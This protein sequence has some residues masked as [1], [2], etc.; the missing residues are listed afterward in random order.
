MAHCHR[1]G[2]AEFRPASERRKCRPDPDPADV[3]GRI[4]D[5][6]AVMTPP[7]LV[8]RR[9]VR[10]RTL[11]HDPELDV[12]V[13][14]VLRVPR[15]VR[16]VRKMG[17]QQSHRCDSLRVVGLQ[18]TDRH[19][20]RLVRVRVVQ[21]LVL[22]N[23]VGVVQMVPRNAIQ[24]HFERMYA[25]RMNVVLRNQELPRSNSPVRAMVPVPDVAADLRRHV[26]TFP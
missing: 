13:Q 2:A 25:V 16:S 14:P 17:A 10:P 9:P 6:T 22:R 12:L 1:V 15:P 19:D 24:L 21:V 3:D 20:E 23:M 7:D 8:D 5:E 18:I 11:M 26:F 4:E